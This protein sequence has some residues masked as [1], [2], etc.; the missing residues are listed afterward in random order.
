MSE[1]GTARPPVRPVRRTR[2]RPPA[3]PPQD[4]GPPGTPAVAPPELPRIPFQ[5]SWPAPTFDDDPPPLPDD[6]PVLIRQ[7]ATLALATA[8]ERRHPVARCRWCGGPFRWVFEQHWLCATEDCAYRQLA[9]A[10]RRRGMSENQSPYL[11]VPLPVQIEVE[12]DMTP[13]LLVA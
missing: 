4:P 6:D 7:A 10:V 9:S 1:W 12:E 5:S 11:F 8:S 13:N 3:E 2:R